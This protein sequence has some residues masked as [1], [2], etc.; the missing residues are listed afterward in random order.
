MTSKATRNLLIA[1][2]AF[3]GLGA[4]GGGAVLIVSPS[5]KLMGM[6][7]SLLD[8]SPFRNYFCLRHYFVFGAWYHPYAFNNIIA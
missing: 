4:M 1:L 8:P 7:L 2:L 5:G 3:L 6:P